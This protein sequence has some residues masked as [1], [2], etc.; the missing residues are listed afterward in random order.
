[1][2]IYRLASIQFSL[3]STASALTRAQA[4]LGVG[5]DA[6]YPEE[7]SVLLLFDRF[8]GETTRKKG[9]NRIGVRS[10]LTIRKRPAV[11][12]GLFLIVHSRWSVGCY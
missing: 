6:H 11:G 1:M 4:A 8:D 3:V 9:P 12:A 10:R 2:L 5:E 7:A